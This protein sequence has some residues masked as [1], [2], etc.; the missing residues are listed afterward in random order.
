V[1][2]QQFDPAE[3]AALALVHQ[4]HAQQTR[5]IAANSTAAATLR[6]IQA[7]L[8]AREAIAANVAPLLAVESMALAL[9]TG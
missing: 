9:R 7:V 4:D 2:V 1:L 6:R 8:D 3:S 5:T